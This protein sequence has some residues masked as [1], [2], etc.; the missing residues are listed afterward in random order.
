MTA[1]KFH[2]NQKFGDF[3]MMMQ[4]RNTASLGFCSWSN[5]ITFQLIN[6]DPK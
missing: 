3:I 5:I 1:Q 6:H 2:Q 4:L